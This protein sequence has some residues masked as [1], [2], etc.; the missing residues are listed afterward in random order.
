MAAVAPADVG[1]LVQADDAE[2][3][4]CTMDV[5]EAAKRTALRES[6]PLLADDPRRQWQELIEAR[7]HLYK[8][9]A[10]AVVA[11]DGRTPE[12]VVQVLL[13]TLP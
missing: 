11:T 13:D 12:E 5:E 3:D 10:T 2:H 8:Q 9:V 6:P 4:G 1:D 7:Q